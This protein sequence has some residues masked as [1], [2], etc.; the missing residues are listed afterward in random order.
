MANKNKHLTKSSLDYNLIYN[1]TWLTFKPLNSETSKKQFM[2]DLVCRYVLLSLETGLRY[3]DLIKLNTNDFIL[4]QPIING[5]IYQYYQANVL[6]DKTKNNV[7][8]KVNFAVF[9]SIVANVNKW[10][11]NNKLFYN[12]IN[13]VGTL[14]L[15]TLNRLLKNFFNNNEISSHSL[16]KTAGYHIYKTSNNLPYAQKMLGHKSLKSTLH[17]L[18]PEQV[19]FDL[20]YI[21]N[22]IK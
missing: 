13:D 20:Y 19:E 11:L 7:C 9:N 21:E 18:A 2:E 5:K 17:Y 14:P 6:M 4:Q 1:H 8:V 3:S 16:R 10:K 15:A 22:M 12:S